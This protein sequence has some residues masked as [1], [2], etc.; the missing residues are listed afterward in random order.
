V[1]AWFETARNVVL[2]ANEDCTY[3][4]LLASTR[5]QRRL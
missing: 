3:D 2:F 4:A 5:K 1:N